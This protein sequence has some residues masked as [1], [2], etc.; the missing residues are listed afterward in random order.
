MRWLLYV[1]ITA[2][3]LASQAQ[4][5]TFEASTP[6]DPSTFAAAQIDYAHH[7]IHEGDAYQGGYLVDLGNAAALN[8]LLTTPNSAKR[9]HCTVEVVSE[10]EVEAGLYEDANASGGTAITVFNRNRNSASATGATLTHTPTITTD[11][12]RIDAW[13]FGS[14]RGVGG[15]ERGVEE[16]LLKQNSKYLLRVT[17]ATATNNQVQVHLHWY[18]HTDKR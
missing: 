7:E 8:L 13:H 17:N 15:S 14:G 10:S 2:L 11:G 4:G 9:L 1:I 16:L 6:L 3:G 12:T 5:L 18:E